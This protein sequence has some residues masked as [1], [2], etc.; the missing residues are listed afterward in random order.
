MT[1]GSTKIG[2][3]SNLVREPNLMQPIQW[4][5]HKRQTYQRASFHGVVCRSSEKPGDE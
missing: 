4:E 5:N 1:E 2:G 3:V